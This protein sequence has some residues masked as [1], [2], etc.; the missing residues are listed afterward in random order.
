MGPAA[1][2]AGAEPI[3]GPGLIRPLNTSCA[4]GVRMASAGGWPPART[5]SSASLAVMTLRM[6]K[7]GLGRRMVED[8][9]DDGCVVGVDRRRLVEGHRRLG[10]LGE[11]DDVAGAGPE[12]VVD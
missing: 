4:D 10:A 5:I 8:G 7:G 11:P 9:L 6:V 3:R 1:F 2:L 12:P